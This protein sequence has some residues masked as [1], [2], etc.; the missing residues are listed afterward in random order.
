VLAFF[1]KLPP[2]LVGIS[3][4]ACPDSDQ[5]LHRS[6]MSRCANRRHAMTEKPSIRRDLDS[7]QDRPAR[8][9][10]NYPEAANA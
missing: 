6:E 8:C 3:M 10:R 9:G 1:Q 2:C 5:V 4:S 7:P